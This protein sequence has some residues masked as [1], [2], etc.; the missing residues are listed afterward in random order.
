MRRA[1]LVFLLVLGVSFP[2]IAQE[3]DTN[4]CQ[5]PA[6]WTDWQEKASKSPDDEELQFLHA[7]WMGLCLKVQAGALSFDKASVIFENARNILI[8]QRREENQNKKP[9]PSL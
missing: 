9:P 8:Q 1:A 5:D 4:H 3:K 6:A 2:T 7:L